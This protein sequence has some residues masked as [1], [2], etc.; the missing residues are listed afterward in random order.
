M[1]RL[2]AFVV[3]VPLAFRPQSPPEPEPLR[4]EK[5]AR[6]VLL[7]GGAGARMIHFGHFETEIHLRHPDHHLVVRNMCD[8]GATPS[9][10]PHS[11]RKN[12]LGFPGAEKF[13]LRYCDG[14]LAPGE[15]F[16]P[17]EEEWLAQ[18]KP[19]LLIGFFGWNESFQG[20]AGLEPF[21]EE[22]DAFVRHTLAQK[23]NGAA[24][25]RL[26]LVSPTAIQDLSGALDVPDG[27]AHNPVLAAYTSVLEAVAQ[28]HGVLFVDAFH[29]SQ[30]WYRESKA[31]LT[32]DGVLLNEAGD[33]KLGEFLAERLF[34]PAPA[35]AGRYRDLVRRAVL[36]KDWMWMNDFKI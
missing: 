19:D 17:S 32:I 20:M 10:R 26:V 33:R 18:L 25:P 13:V 23:Y 15:G 4:L 24:P 14:R 12:Q 21:R 6:I 2:T 29:T 35:A 22:L 9:F 8:E 5:N 11:A 1:T 3:L 16:F 36:E 31:P 30:A 27:K 34:G 28:K 7:G